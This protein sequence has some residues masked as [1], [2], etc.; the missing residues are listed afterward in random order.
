M[1]R[2]GN[3]CGA[4][5]SA[6]AL[7]ISAIAHADNPPSKLPSPAAPDKPPPGYHDMTINVGGKPM[8]IRVPDEHKNTLKNSSPANSGPYDPTNLDL[9]HASVYSNKTF[10][11]SSAI[12]SNDDGTNLTHGQKRFETSSFATGA[13]NQSDRTF[14]TAAYKSSSSRNSDDFSKSYQLPAAASG[15]NRSFDVKGS[16]L[17]NKKALIAD[18]PKDKVDPFATP[19]S[20]GDK[21]FFDPALTHVK[22]DPYAPANVDTKKLN[23]LPN[24]PLTI[25]EVRRLINHEQVPDLDKPPEP[26]SGPLNDPNFVPKLDTAVSSKAAPATPPPDETKEDELPSPGMMAKPVNDQPLP[27]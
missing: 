27:K 16:D 23:D 10:S 22:R 6:L 4:L 14:Q 7:A 5:F 20:E 1:S 19:W 9:N 21:R 11:T 12:L 25:D 17:Q 15:L 18:N 24:R 3:R 2:R 13:Y 26:E 8:T